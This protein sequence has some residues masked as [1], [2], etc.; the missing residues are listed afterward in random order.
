MNWQAA[1]AVIG[2]ITG[3]VSLI[4]IVYGLIFKLG[5]LKGWKESVDDWQK[6][7]DAAE[8]DYSPK[9]TALMCKTMWDIYVIGPLRDR[10]DLATHRSPL[11]LTPYSES[12]IT[13]DLK[14]ILNLIKTDRQDK[15][16]IATGWLVVKYLGVGKIEQLSVEKDL[17]IPE[18]IAVLSTYVDELSSNHHS[19]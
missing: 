1:A 7:H 4:T 16:N 18:M 8:K 2:V 5:W 13:D 12:I 15:E 6:K 3:V 17:S 14:K 19:G 10:P 9:E 11:K